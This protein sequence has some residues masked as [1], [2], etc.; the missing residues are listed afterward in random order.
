MDGW[1][2]EWINNTDI[3]QEKSVPH[4]DSD[5]VFP[6]TLVVTLFI[7]YCCIT[8]YY[9]LSGL[10]QHKSITSQCHR[11]EI[12]VQH[13]W[14]LCWEFH[15]T[16]LK[17]LAGAVILLK[18]PVPLLRFLITGRFQFLEVRGLRSHLCQTAKTKSYVIMK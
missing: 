7:F 12:Q 15:K 3:A 5:L 10:Q 13:G 17:V 8:T 9:K 6:F 16:E 11:T 18:A 2:T 1:L 4:G 14:V